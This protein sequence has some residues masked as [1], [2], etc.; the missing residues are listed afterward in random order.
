VSYSNTTFGR[1][2]DTGVKKPRTPNTTWISH[3]GWYHEHL[4]DS[5][6]QGLRKGFERQ[7]CAACW[8]RGRELVEGKIVTFWKPGT[9][10]DSEE[11]QDEIAKKSMYVGPHNKDKCTVCDRL[12][13]KGFRG[14]CLKFADFLGNGWV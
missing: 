12:D 5:E 9:S 6:N 3:C 2:T 10:P 8:R 11:E 1:A 13:K 14:T 7:F 4:K